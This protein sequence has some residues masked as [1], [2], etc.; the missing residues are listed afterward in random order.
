DVD[1]QPGSISFGE[2]EQGSPADQQV[3]VTYRGAAN[4]QI[5]DVRS[6]NTH[7]EVD[8]SDP[9]R[10]PGQV[11]YKMQVHLKPDAPAGLLQDQLTIVTNDARMKT[12]AL[13][14]EGRIMPPL[15]VSPSPLLFGTLAPGQSATKP[16]VLSGKQPFKVVSI[17]TDAGALQFK[18]STEVSK[19]VH[20]VPV[21]VTAP[22]QSGE[23]RYT[24]TIESD[25]PSGGQATC[26]V[27]GHV[28]GD[29]ATAPT[30]ADRNG[31]KR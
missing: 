26:Q 23:F 27:R 15:S 10:Q 2:V 3:V 30:S 25:L 17:S 7:L 29:S 24:V 14:I 18:V 28:R 21:T 22:E 4:W 6:A 11:S 5:A 20:L 1:F 16:I 9:V 8:L 31:I 13:P 19:K 12:V